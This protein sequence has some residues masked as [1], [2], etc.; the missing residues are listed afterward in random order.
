ML[1]L[2]GDFETTTTPDDVRV[3]ASC[4]VNVDNNKV[5][6]LS[7]NIDSFF[8]F[9]KDKN[10]KIYFHNEKFDGEF[11]I[12]HL[13]SKLKFKCDD[14]K[15]P[16]T[17]STLI[18]DSGIFYCITIYF[19]KFNKRYHK[20]QIL[21][22]L[23]KLPF[24]VS[25]IA[26]TF[27]L[28]ESK[29][30]ID[31]DEK[32]DVGHILTQDEKDYIISDCVIVA[33]ALKHQFD[34][35][36]TKMTI[37]ADALSGFKN[38]V[39]R[40]RF[41]QWFPLLPV[42]IDD[43]IRRAYKG[44]FTYLNPR[45]KNKRLQGGVFDVNSLYPSVMYYNDLPYGYPLYYDGEYK[46]DANYPLYIQHLRCE[47]K[48]KKNHIPT[49]QLKNNPAYVDTEY[50]T[51]SKGSIEELTMTNIDLEL[52]LEHY[53]VYNLEFINGYKF[54]KC[55][56]V[57]KEYIDYWSNVKSESKINGN[58]GMY[59]I[60]KLMLNSLYGKFASNPH[61][62]NKTPYLE[63]NIVHYVIGEET[64]KDPVYTAVGCFITAWARYKTITSA[65]KLFDRFIYGD[66]DSL[67]LENYEIPS[68]LEIH[69]TK[70]GAW[71]HEGSF[72]D[73]KFLRAKT[74]METIDGH[75]HVKCAG[76]PDNVKE[77]VTYDNFTVGA[78]FGGKLR[79][80]RYAGGIIL[81]PTDFTIKGGK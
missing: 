64:L 26:K 30:K 69:D 33:K 75:T 22:S 15:E 17:F 32:R 60:S 38:L 4:L 73:S 50:L 81:T 37:G 74:Y 6:H 67:H 63:N 12:H 10:T 53:D 79:P 9:I 18:T 25:T 70:L 48:L 65:Q 49:I 8:D 47:F 11:I 36:L 72:T 68:N 80:T 19:H 61:S 42:E 78:S 29:L 34:A 21:D 54:K 2:V 14:S 13:L 40:K 5:E 44:G 28:E 57:F 35:G 56:G 3:W 66:T 1:T 23:K 52:M 59:T 41:E 77:K 71:K 43:E 58:G 20:C 24:P 62:K 27:K 16:G 55:N 76:M 51:S 7:N 31:Y 39:S 46:T 45:Y